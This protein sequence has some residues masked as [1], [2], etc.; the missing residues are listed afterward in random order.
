MQRLK[1]AV[2][3]LIALIVIFS[4]F[5][6]PEISFAKSK[7][8]PNFSLKVLNP[9]LSGYKNIDLRSLEGKTVIINFWA[10]WCPPCREEIPHFV[11]FYNKNKS[12]KLMIIGINVNV[13]TEGVR[14]FT[15]Q[16]K[17]DYPVVHATNKVLSEYG[18]IKEIPQTFFVSKSGIIVFHWKGYMYEEVL[19]IV[20]Q[21]LM[22]MKMMKIM[23]MMKK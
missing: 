15:H 8:A 9:D 19:N 5:V 14:A 2:I 18:G 13:T 23:K 10:T 7:K 16:Y 3:L 12:K 17:M 11:S 22:R 1:S 4:I 21:R 6:F 20:S